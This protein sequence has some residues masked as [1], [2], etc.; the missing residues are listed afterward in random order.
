MTEHIER[1]LKANVKKI[2]C[3][4]SDCTKML[5]PADVL[6]ITGDISKKL[7]Y[8]ELRE[9]FQAAKDP[10][11]YICPAPNCGYPGRKPILIHGLSDI[12]ESDQLETVCCDKCGKEVVFFH[13]P[14]Q[15][16]PVML[17]DTNAEEVKSEE[18]IQKKLDSGE[19]QRCPSCN[20]PQEK[21]PGCNHVTCVNCDEQ[22][23]WF[24]GKLWGRGYEDHVYCVFSRPAV[25][26]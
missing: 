6:R 16:Y 12:N 21:Q 11:R 5:T 10:S 7:K 18:E 15:G 3:P 20:N 17:G 14:G 8:E 1:A 4:G 25:H 26:L 9:V 2:E 19:M 22:Y 23:C 24:C 13:V